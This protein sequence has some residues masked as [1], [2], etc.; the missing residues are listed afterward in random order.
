MYCSSNFESPAC[1]CGFVSTIH[2]NV[3][4]APSDVIASTH[5]AI[6]FAQV[7]IGLQ[8]PSQSGWETDGLHWLVSVRGP[9]VWTYLWWP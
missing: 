4:S 8:H 3:L 6:A 5:P 2:T 1:A 9:F 7:E